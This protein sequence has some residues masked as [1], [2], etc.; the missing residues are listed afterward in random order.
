MAEAAK[1]R[2]GGGSEKEQLAD[3]ILKRQEKGA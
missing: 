1:I 2:A 3:N